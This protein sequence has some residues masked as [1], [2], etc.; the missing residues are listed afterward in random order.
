LHTIVPDHWM[1]IAVIARQRGWSQRETAVAALRAG[2]G[3]VLST[4]L[5][6]V[7]VWLAGAAAAERFGRVVD[8]ASSLALVGFGCWIAASAWDELRRA[9]GHGHQ[10][11]HG[12]SHDRGHGHAHSRAPHLPAPAP[13]DPLY[14]PLRG[15]AVL[16]RHVHPH[17]HGS[18]RSHSHWHDHVAAT[19]HPIFADAAP[20]HEHRHKTTG[21]TALLLIL[22]SSPMVEGI[23]L[24]FAAAPY[25]AATIAGMAFAFAASTILTYVLLCVGS[26]AGLQRLR[27]G[28]VEAWGEV[29]SGGLI[30]LVGL[31]FWLWPP[32]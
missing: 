22:G 2:S 29:L 27:F 4:L 5:I 7:A 18:G 16:T 24:F 20:A 19:A 31:A 13:A 6:G 8:I 23:P 12:H 21:R 1:P 14:V 30:A 9:R 15:A 28:A 3:H 11:H 26:A 17:R 25:G 10:H 32:L